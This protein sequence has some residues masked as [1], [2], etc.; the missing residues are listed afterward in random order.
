MESNKMIGVNIP[1]GLR[2]RPAKQS[3]APFLER[4]HHAQRTDLQWIDGEQDF[5]ESIVEMQ[6]H[7][8]RKGYGEQFPNAM[9]F[10]VEKHH[11]LI[12]KATVDFGHNE[13]HLIDLAFIPKARGL[14]FGK[15]VLQSLQQAAAQSGVPMSLCVLQ[16]NVMA[17]RLY[18]SLGF[19]VEGSRPPYEEMRWYPSGRKSIFEWRSSLS[20]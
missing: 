8:Q 17:K 12:G 11:E 13:A 10:V 20:Q 18:Q 15:A 4:L 16:S 19:V 5:I 2:V 1:E 7:A 6:L 3:D 9:Y 14:G